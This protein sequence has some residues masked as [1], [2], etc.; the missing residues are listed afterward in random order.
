MIDPA[1]LNRLLDATT[2]EEL[3]DIHT[4]VM[5][6]YGFDR[7][8]YG[9]TQFRTATSLGCPEDFVVL[10]NHAPDYTETYVND[11]LYFHAPM[12]RWSLE[13]DGACS[14]SVLDARF[15]ADDFTPEERKVLAFNRKHGVTAGYSISFRSLRPRM[16]A[17]IALTAREGMTQAEVDARWQRDGATIFA[18]N[19]VVHRCIMC[20]PYDSPRRPLT[21]RQREVLDWVGDGKTVQDIALLMGLTPATVEKH[22]RLA[23]RALSVETTAQAILKAAFQNQ[24]FTLNRR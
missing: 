5:A 24:I 7:L 2:M 20:L 15:E 12:V 21:D 3:W 4:R 17:A 14:W 19:N 1:V 22:L 9:A 11:G 16:K 10:T 23:R 8:I 6:G 13:N 18:L